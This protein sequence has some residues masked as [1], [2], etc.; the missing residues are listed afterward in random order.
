M[1]LLAVARRLQLRQLL[2]Q[3]IALRHQPLAVAR[4]HPVQLHRLPDEVGD[5]GQQSDIGIEPEHRPLVEDAV[6]AQRAN[7]LV[8]DPDRHANE[9]HARTV[10]RAQHIHVGSAEGRMGRDVLGDQRHRRRNDLV[11]RLLRQA[12]AVALVAAF[13]PAGTHGNVGYA[14]IGQ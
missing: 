5:H 9:R 8:V 6:D 10:G 14:V 2:L 4:D 1:D 13:A 12:H 7:D 11:D 3:P